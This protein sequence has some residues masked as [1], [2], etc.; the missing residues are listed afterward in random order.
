MNANL[1]P[2]KR[3]ARVCVLE[4][5]KIKCKKAYPL[6]YIKGHCDH[7]NSVQEKVRPRNQLP[8]EIIINRG[9]TYS[10][11]NSRFRKELSQN[12]VISDNL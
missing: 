6:K 5:S 2:E 3:M 11:R 12:T 9:E 1:P 8:E 10:L 7:Q 4:V